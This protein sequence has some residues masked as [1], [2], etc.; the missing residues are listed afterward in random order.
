MP[1]KKKKEAAE[2]APKKAAPRKKKVAPKVEPTG[3]AADA[4]G[5]AQDDPSIAALGQHVVLAGGAVLGAYRDPLG[6][7][8]LL[9]VSLPIDKIAPT[10]FQRDV[11]P[12]HVKKLAVAIGKTRRFLDPVIAMRE[13]DG[14]FLTPNGNHRLTVMRE[15]GARSIVAI[16]V[17]ERTVA[18]Q[19]L[20][21][22][23]EKAHNLRERA[24][25]VRRMMVDLAGWA[26]GSEK[27]FDLEL[28]EPSLVTIGFAYEERP[29]LSGGAYVPVLK[30]VDAWVPGTL[31]EAVTER[32]RRAALVL[33]LDDAVEGAVERLK[34]AGLTSPYLRA[35]VV[36]RV[37]PLRFIKGEPP[38]LDDLMAT[39][40]KRASGLDAGK[41]SSN[42][43]ARS[44][45][46]PDDE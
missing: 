46:A 9:L 18:Y 20:A 24:M 41:I 10:S 22:N 43:L 17:P 28:D 6:G 5:L 21:L 31:T 15:L 3:L 45:G 44:G 35:F 39:M 7:H 11:S 25:E 2:S 32:R 27:D 16:L 30:K 12:G 40:T 37:N 23:T 29:R 4:L 33:G 19:I 8:P 1:P 36:A 26:K 34:A 14:R 13:D 38:P 42:D